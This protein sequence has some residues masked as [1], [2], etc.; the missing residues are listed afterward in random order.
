MKTLLILITFVLLV[1]NASIAQK[2]IDN[3]RF[4]YGGEELKPQWIGISGGLG[5]EVGVSAGYGKTIGIYGNFK[6]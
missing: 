5:P 1:T 2:H 3:I 6:P 4:V